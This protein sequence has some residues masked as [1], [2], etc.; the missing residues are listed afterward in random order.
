ME[1]ER[2]QTYWLSSTIPID[3]YDYIGSLGQEHFIINHRF[4]IQNAY[5]YC[6]AMGGQEKYEK[7]KSVIAKYF[8]LFLLKRPTKCVNVNTFEPLKEY[9]AS[10][11]ITLYVLIYLDDHKK[12][13]NITEENE[14]KPEEFFYEK[15]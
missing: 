5:D 8:N 9:K 10:N 3:L 14:Y 13:F 15:G 7:L 4:I 2:K 1:E 11:L 12:E 6:E